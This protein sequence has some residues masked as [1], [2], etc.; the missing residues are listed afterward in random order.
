MHSCLF[1]FPLWLYCS[2]HSFLEI[3]I[4]IIVTKEK[5][6]TLWH[7]YQTRAKARIMSEIEEVQEQ[8]KA[9]MDAMKEQMTKMMEAMMSMRKMME[10]NTTT[11]VAA[12]IATE[13]DPIHPT[14][15]NQVNRPV[16]DLVVQGGEATKNACGPHHV[17]V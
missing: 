3:R 13:M 11:V 16:L 6:R 1:V 7:P 17:Q 5:D 10:D 9:N 8:L 15:F 2:L 14:G 4:V 12:S